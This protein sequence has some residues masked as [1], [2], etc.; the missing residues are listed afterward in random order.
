[1]ASSARASVESGKVEMTGKTSAAIK[2]GGRVRQDTPP[3]AQTNLA[4]R[5]LAGGRPSSPP[6]TKK[7]KV[8]SLVFI[9][10]CMYA[11]SVHVCGSHLALCK[12]TMLYLVK[13]KKKEKC[14]V[15]L[16]DRSR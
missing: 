7:G 10:P 6:P 1:M 16:S 8:C 11:V 4:R 3:S 14:Y 15:V 12:T 13:K 2:Q 5:P 9:E